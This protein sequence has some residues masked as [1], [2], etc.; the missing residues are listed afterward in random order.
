MPRGRILRAKR[1]RVFVA[2]EGE[3]ERGYV[4]FVGQLA[5]EARL[6]VHLDIRLCNGG[7]PLAIVECA[8]DDMC[9]RTSRRGN[10]VERAIFLDDDRR[11]DAP[12]RTMQADR[13]IEANGLR[14]IWSQPVLEALLLRHLPGCERLR[15]A[16]SELALREL[17]RRWPEYVKGM[18]ARE[19]RRTLDLA[20]V[21]RAAAEDVQLRSFLTAIGLLP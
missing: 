15:P 8:V 5:E 9:R 17:K 3:S 11:G 20:A 21:E 13:L 18:S 16:T 6:P 12:D 1:R 19:L 4:A 14:P 2:C 7:D 10:Y